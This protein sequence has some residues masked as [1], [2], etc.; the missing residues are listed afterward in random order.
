MV[1]DRHNTCYQPA[2]T[3]R[4]DDVILSN[5]A[6]PCALVDAPDRFGG[7]P[8]GDCLTGDLVIRQGQVAGLRLGD[9]R[10]AAATRIVM[11]ALTE[12]HVH[13]DKCHSAHRLGAVGGNL[14]QAIA[15]QAED[16]E[17]WTAEDLRARMGRGLAELV[18]AGCGQV[19]S[20]IDWSDS[21]AP[22]LAW[23]ILRE[24]AA[25]HDVDVQRSPLT[26]IDQMAKPGMADAIAREAAQ[27]RQGVLGAFVLDH[28]N[29]AAGMRA[30]F[31]AADRYGLALDFHVD[32]G[33]EDGL[34]GVSLIAQTVIETGFAGPIL[35]GHGCSLMNLEGDA[36]A[37]TIDLVADAGLYVAALPTSNLY[38]QGRGE[39]TPDRRGITRL[40]EL[41]KAG[42]RVLV[43]TDN[44]R[45][46]FCPLGR[47]D[48]RASL[49]LAVLGAH[50]DPP[51]GA[52]LSMITTDA[53]RALGHAPC[54]VDGA[55]PAALRVYAGGTTADFLTGTDSPI[56]LEAALAEA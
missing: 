26:G 28:P 43:G 39:G 21:A 3:P 34:D 38:L 1:K 49:S 19:R 17:N 44:V 33:L 13:L 35:C 5:V 45:D 11:R 32:E 6:V 23:S 9:S 30:M 14:R 8:V 54:Y 27:D 37:R 25:D 22:P 48:P 29:R 15:A 51:F 31:R 40:S 50:L 53:A 55:E 16:R 36:L 46:A 20:H 56:S 2:A 42:V 18:A 10:D 24:V 47:F 12:T 4:P 41:R 7:R 52:H